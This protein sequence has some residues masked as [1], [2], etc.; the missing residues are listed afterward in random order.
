MALSLSSK[1]EF[2]RLCALF[3]NLSKTKG[4]ERQGHLQKFTREVR[5]VA[6]KLKAQDP[7]AV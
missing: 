4:V 7:N 1:I 2:K 6:R 3:E 5:D